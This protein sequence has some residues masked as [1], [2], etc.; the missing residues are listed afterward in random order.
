MGMGERAAILGGQVNISS[1]L[2][3][4]TT[5]SAWIPLP[6]QRKSGTLAAAAAT[7]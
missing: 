5:V 6:S 1:V 4:G 3:K 7:A 2:G